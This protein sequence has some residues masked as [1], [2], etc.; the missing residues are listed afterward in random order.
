[1]CLSCYALPWHTPREMRRALA[2]YREANDEN[3]DVDADAD[4]DIRTHTG[5]MYEHAGTGR[6]SE[7]AGTTSSSPTPAERP[8]VCM[9]LR[10]HAAARLLHIRHVALYWCTLYMCCMS[11]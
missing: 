4:A 7:H 8:Q 3:T 6:L 1:M 5:G 9:L 10:M 11:A 2:A